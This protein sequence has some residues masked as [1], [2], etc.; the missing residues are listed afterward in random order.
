MLCISEHH[1]GVDELSIFSMTKYKM[2]TGFSRNMS[3]NG[4]V[5]ILVKNNITYQK[6]DLNKLKRE[7]VFECCED[8]Y[9]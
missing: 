1:L 7:K 8:K 3:K 2:A 6:L 5:C 9:K 4:G